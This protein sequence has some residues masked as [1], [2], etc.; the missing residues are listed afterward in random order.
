MNAIKKLLGIVWM[1]LGPAA[2]Y[3]M[4]SQAAIKIGAANTKIEKAADEVAKAVEIAA[5]TNITLQWGIIIGIFVPVAIGMCIFGFYALK[6]EY[7]S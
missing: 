1:A 3:F 4:V 6:G 2:V 5:K 7:D